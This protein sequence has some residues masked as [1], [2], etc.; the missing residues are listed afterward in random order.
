MDRATACRG[1]GG[2]A[3]QPD[4]RAQGWGVQVK[5]RQERRAAMVREIHLPA[6]QRTLIYEGAFPHVLG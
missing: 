6:P 5:P 3:G 1:T 4:M 2:G